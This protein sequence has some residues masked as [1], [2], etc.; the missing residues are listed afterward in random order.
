MVARVVVGAHHVGIWCHVGRRRRHGT[1]WSVLHHVV[2]WPLEG[3][4]IVTRPAADNLLL[5]HQL[6]NARGDHPHQVKCGWLGRWL[7]DNDLGVRLG[8]VERGV[9]SGQRRSDTIDLEWRQWGL[10]AGVPV[11]I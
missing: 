11:T 2:R 10:D 4:W 7:W 9:V 6:V 5:V 1:R 8:R 3:G